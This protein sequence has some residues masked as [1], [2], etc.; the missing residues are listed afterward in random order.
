MKNIKEKREIKKI[1]SIAFFIMLLSVSLISC[2]K[3][4][5]VG[6]FPLFNKGTYANIIKDA[7]DK[8]EQ[9]SGNKGIE[10]LYENVIYQEINSKYETQASRNDVEIA[11]YIVTL[12]PDINNKKIVN[13]QCRVMKSDFTREVEQYLKSKDTLVS[14]EKEIMENVKTINENRHRTGSIDFKLDIKGIEGSI[15]G[16]A[17][18][19][20]FDGVNVE[21][22][23][24]KINDMLDDKLIAGATSVTTIIDKFREN[25]GQKA[26]QF[27]ANL[28]DETYYYLTLLFAPKI[29]SK[30][31]KIK[32]ET[33]LNNLNN[34]ISISRYNKL[35]K[36][37]I[38]NGSNVEDDIE[39]ENKDL[40]EKTL[41]EKG[42][43]KEDAESFNS[44]ST[45][46]TEV[47]GYIKYKIPDDFTIEKINKDE[48]RYYIE[49]DN[50]NITFSRNNDVIKNSNELSEKYA[51]NELDS[52]ISSIIK[53]Y[54]DKSANLYKSSE[55]EVCG[56][57][58]A[59]KFHLLSDE[60]YYEVVMFFDNNTL[61]TEDSNDDMCMFIIF[62]EPIT[63]RY[64][65]KNDF[66]KI[67][68]SISKLKPIE[69]IDDLSN[70]KKLGFNEAKKQLEDMGFFKFD[71]H[72]EKESRGAL[73]LGL[74][75]VH[76]END[77]KELKIEN[78]EKWTANS[79]IREDAIVTITYYNTDIYEESKEDAEKFKESIEDA[80]K[81]AEIEEEERTYNE[82]LEENLN[83]LV[84]EYEK[85]YEKKY[86]GLEFDYSNNK[87][88]II[89]ETIIS[90]SGI[91]KNDVIS[92]IGSTNTN[93]EQVCERFVDNNGEMLSTEKLKEILN[94]PE[95][96]IKDVK[97]QYVL[98][99][100]EK[101]FVTIE[102]KNGLKTYK[103]YK[104]LTL[105]E[106]YYD[107]ISSGMFVTGDGSE[108]NINWFVFCINKDSIAEKAGLKQNDIIKVIDDENYEGEGINGAVEEIREKAGTKQTIVVKR[109]IEGSDDYEELT[110]ELQY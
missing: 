28:D 23:I 27:I 37:Y 72:T 5:D 98:G 36:Q 62:E 110:F 51:N 101:L 11:S 103:E 80:L 47:L 86:I 13:Y 104:I 108:D 49:Q 10:Y 105:D 40:Y 61:T 48:R 93:G 70:I 79:K 81:Q 74:L 38:P 53:S 87:Y 33:V 54:Y 82:S 16:G 50:V 30:P 71:I 31:K 99:D 63:G 67:I 68:N 85:A 97:K 19:G 75:G 46:G 96:E 35:K 109:H 7:K 52:D 69:L 102:R 41:E 92:F 32:E 83:K 20:K 1:F 84:K 91:N 88:S 55:F 89:D 106:N 22:D 95:G 59:N 65:Y 9:D 18:K 4:D 58:N 34:N 24:G 6:E 78:S 43:E 94:T 44:L 21:T 77:I 8:Y 76:K 100:N 14:L 56:E 2:K 42:I 39:E 45:K 60:K 73:G 66:A 17:V 64:E 25:K 57:I 90:K 3:K 12:V 107:N 29:K 26:E 15:G